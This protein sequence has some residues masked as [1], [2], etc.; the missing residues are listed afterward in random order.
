VDG[1]LVE[2]TFWCGPLAEV[3]RRATL[4]SGARPPEQLTGTGEDDA[5]VGPVRRYLYAPDD[6]VVRAH[7]VAE[8]AAGIDGTLADPSIAYVYADNAVATPYARCLEIVDVAPF[9][10][11]RLRALLRSR[12]V[13]RVE[14]LK[15]GSAVDVERLRRDLRLAGTGQASI[16]LTRVAGD[17]SVLLCRPVPATG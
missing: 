5:P 8:F 13:G 1:A 3:P 11:K 2:A 14:I 7:L 17:A 9:S 12:D 10:L 16:V 15:R 6:A 4:L